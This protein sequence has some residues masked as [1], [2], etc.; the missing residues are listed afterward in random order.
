MSSV[1]ERTRRNPI[2]ADEYREALLHAA[3]HLALDRQDVISLAEALS[4]RAWDNCGP[5]ELAIVIQHLRDCIRRTLAKQ[6][7]EIGGSHA[8]EQ[9]EDAC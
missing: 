8:T 5:E 1:R 9:E 3:C 2:S 6:I 4:G 7:T